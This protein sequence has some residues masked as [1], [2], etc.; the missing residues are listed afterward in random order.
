IARLARKSLTSFCHWSAPSS[1]PTKTL[2]IRSVSTLWGKPPTYSK[3]AMRQRMRVGASERLVKQAKRMR[4]TLRIA[5]KPKNLCLTLM[6]DSG[7]LIRKFAPV[8]L[9]LL[10]R[11]GFVADHGPFASTRRTQRMHEGF[12]L[13]DAAGIAQWPEASEHTHAVSAMTLLKPGA[14]LLLVGVDF[15]PFVFARLRRRCSL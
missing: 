13:R 1:T 12:E 9:Q 15:A 7:F 4:E 10:S 8:K 6:P 3:A 2:V 5:R 14:N 11:S